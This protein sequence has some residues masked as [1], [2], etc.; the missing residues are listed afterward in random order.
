ME[1]DDY[2]YMAKLA[3]Q[4]E[5]YDGKFWKGKKN[6]LSNSLFLSYRNGGKYEE[7]SLYEFGINR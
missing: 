1:R 5:R 6:V 4:A 7:S 3:E 2:V